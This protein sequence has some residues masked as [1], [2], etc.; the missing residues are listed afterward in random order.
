MVSVNPKGV[1]T[2]RFRNTDLD[3]LSRIQLK[4]ALISV[5]MFSIVIVTNHS[6]LGKRIS[7]EK[8]PLTG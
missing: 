6:H 4:E 3:L 5:P 1:L 2:H 7:I 8:L